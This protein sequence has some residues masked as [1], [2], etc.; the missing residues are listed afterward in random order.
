MTVC[1]LDSSLTAF[2][3]QGALKL[4]RCSEDLQHESGGRIPVI[5][6][7]PLGHSDE[8]DTTALQDLDVVEAVYK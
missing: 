7:Q 5:C 3:D 2:K 4:S 1:P 6:V 8:S